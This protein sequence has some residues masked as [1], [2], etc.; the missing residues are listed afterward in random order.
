MVFLLSIYTRKSAVGVYV[1]SIHFD[2]VK[3]VLPKLSITA[4][5]YYQFNTDVY[6]LTLKTHK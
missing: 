2:Y 6:Y 3:C 5:L 1:N 4:M